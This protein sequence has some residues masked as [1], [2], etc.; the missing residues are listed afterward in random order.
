MYA[1]DQA[2]VSTPGSPLAWLTW[3]YEGE[4]FRVALNHPAMRLGR[5]SNC[6]VP[7]PDTCV[8]RHHATIE[9]SAVGWT[10]VDQGSRN[11]TF[12]NRRRI[13]R[14]KLSNGDQI[15]FSSVPLLRI[16]F[17]DGGD[18][19]ALVDGPPERG[20]LA[21]TTSF[22]MGEIVSS[23]PIRRLAE[24]KADGNTSGEPAGAAHHSGHWLIRLFSQLGEAL[25]ATTELDELLSKILDLVFEDLPAERG[26]VCLRDGATGAILP[27]ATRRGSVNEPITISR[28]VV[29]EVLDAQRAVIIGNATEDAR[30]GGAQSIVDLKIHSAMCAPLYHEGK[31]LG[32]IY[33]DNQSSSQP[34][35]AGDLEVLTS[36][37]VFAAVGVEQW[38]LRE[39]VDREKEIRSRLERYSS[40]AVV[41]QIVESQGAPEMLAEEKEV[42]VLF[43][44]L[45]GFTNLSQNMEPR[46]VAELLNGLFERLTDVL[47]ACGGTLDKFTGD[48]VMAVFG[49]PLEQSDHAVRAIRAALD[50]QKVIGELNQARAGEAALA[51]RIGLN[52]GRVVAGDIGSPRRRDYSV[53]GDAVN[54]ASRLESSVALPGQVIVGPETY[55]LAKERF[56]FERLEEIQLR[57][58]EE[59][60]R[61]Y[62]V[63]GGE[64]TAR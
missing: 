28:S 22:S 34:F 2:T 19:V 41:D 44:D 36:F 52:S 18:Q 8:S 31:V 51:M 55:Q 56:Q 32:F 12:V 40:P 53:L 60:V 6:N 54:I 35:A 59:K 21:V 27:R 50:M 63:I 38:R 9:Q 42:T 37:A 5:A 64:R 57:G 49:A 14:H 61:P 16:T 62:R 48:G 3:A 25:L 43:A 20:G 24:G 13:D 46:Q 15:T 7:L 26:S 39:A 23:G 45:A 4:S 29:H 47:F 33:V 10:I 1:D 17:H 58:K 30:V 11:G